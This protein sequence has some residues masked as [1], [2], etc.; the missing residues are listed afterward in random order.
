MTVDIIME[1]PL[2][3]KG[4]LQLGYKQCDGGMTVGVEPVYCRLVI[5]EDCGLYPDIWFPLRSQKSQTKL[6]KS[7]EESGG[8]IPQEILLDCYSYAW[9][10][11]YNQI[12]STSHS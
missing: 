10:C 12:K 7:I 8:F 5:P 3:I 6:L 2:Y 1:F 4:T 9:E 11:L